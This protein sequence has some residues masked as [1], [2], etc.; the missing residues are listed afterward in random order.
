[1]DTSESSRDR[2]VENKVMP[3]LRLHERGGP[4]QLVYEGAP[5]PVVGIG[6]VL[7]RVQAASITPTELT[8]PSTWI[9]RAGRDRRPVIPSH[10]VAGV[11]EA[12]GYGTTGVNIGDAVYGLTDWYRDGAVAAYVAVE[13]RN[14]AR[15]PASLS[16]VETA[17]VPL[18]GLTAW[19]ALFDHGGLEAGQIALIHG[20]GGGV[21]TFAIQLAKGAGAR[22]VATG[23]G[24]A[25]QLAADLG[26]DTYIDLDREPFEAVAPPADL[27]FDLIGGDIL[28]RSWSVVKQGGVL[29]SVVG[30]PRAT[31]AQAGV[32]SVFFVVEPDRVELAT[33][34]R[35]IDAGE[36]R[37]IVGAVL[38]LAEGRKAFEAKAADGVPGKT[39][40][41][42][43][44]ES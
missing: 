38:P 20:A 10:E 16:P 9:D 19:Q 37:P 17:A 28:Q 31:G 15:Q 40:L 30:D 27:V 32:R 21:G 44:G 1:M 33:L 2:S 4:E 6:D 43:A 23:R 42:V 11:V 26:A 5:M 25:R 22:V 35:R 34:A 7:I 8:W 12:L 29:I 18:A 39:V 41:D 13:A 24:W 36:L 3:A 14:L